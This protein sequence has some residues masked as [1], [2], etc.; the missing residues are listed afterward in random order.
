MKNRLFTILLLLLLSLAGAFGQEA[1]ELAIF[2]EPT[3]FLDTMTPQQVFLEMLKTADAMDPISEEAIHLTFEFAV[4]AHPEILNEETLPRIL[5]LH[6]HHPESSEAA[7]GYSL[8]LANIGQFEQAIALNMEFLKANQFGKGTAQMLDFLTGLYGEMPDESRDV[9]LGLLPLMRK[10]DA[11]Y[12]S[13]L[14]FV[15]LA[16]D[17]AIAR[18]N[19]EDVAELRK[20]LTKRLDFLKFKGGM[21]LDNLD[22][23]AAE[24]CAQLLMVTDIRILNALL[25]EFDAMM[26]E[27]SHPD[28]SCVNCDDVFCIVRMLCALVA[29][30]D[31]FANQILSA[32]G[33]ADAERA[34]MTL[35]VFCKVCLELQSIEFDGYAHHLLAAMVQKNNDPRFHQTMKLLLLD[36]MDKELDFDLNELDDDKGTWLYVLGYASAVFFQNYEAVKPWILESKNCQDAASLEELRRRVPPDLRVRFINGAIFAERFCQPDLAISLSE[37]ALRIYPDDPH[38]LN[39]LG[40]FISNHGGNLDDAILYIK[41]ALIQDMGNDAYRDSLAWAYQL[42]GRYGE[43]KREMKMVVWNLLRK[44]KVISPDILEHFEIIF[45]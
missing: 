25:E 16:V 44:G 30:N 29:E 45:K 14:Y 35:I 6:Q 9:F 38:I 37:D 36:A 31:T 10:A 33:S 41:R 42:A 2:M 5:E 24:V 32:V 20:S 4:N 26:P 8:A 39:Q 17:C 22:D 34:R 15:W 1:R 7:F 18:A 23:V 13:A 19:G 21:E 12:E 27:I 40:Y 11:Q 28:L 3:A 43:A